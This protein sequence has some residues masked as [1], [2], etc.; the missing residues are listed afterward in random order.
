MEL[1]YELVPGGMLA[2]AGPVPAPWRVRRYTV[3]ARQPL[4]KKSTRQ[5]H[6]TVRPPVVYRIQAK[7]LS[8]Y[9]KRAG[10]YYEEL[11]EPLRIG[12]LAVGA[13]IELS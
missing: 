13:T 12:I 9:F 2:E 3:G 10:E 11:A 1:L 5:V 4:L 6:A 8:I 7:T